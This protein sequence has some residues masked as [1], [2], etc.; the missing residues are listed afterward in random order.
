MQGKGAGAVNRVELE[1]Q[2][3][4]AALRQSWVREDKV[5]A[6]TSI[7][8][9]SHL[10]PDL[11]PPPEER[12]GSNKANYYDSISIKPQAGLNGIV[13]G[14]L[15]AVR[16]FLKDYN[17]RDYKDY[18]NTILNAGFVLRK[19]RLRLSHD[20]VVARRWLYESQLEEDYPEEEAAAA[21]LYAETEFELGT[22]AETAEETPAAAQMQYEVDLGTETELEAAEAA[23]QAAPDFQ[24]EAAEAA[25]PLDLW[26]ISAPAQESEAKEAHPEPA[27]SAASAQ[28]SSS[29]GSKSDDD[30]YDPLAAIEESWQEARRRSG[31]IAKPSFSP[32]ESLDLPQKAG[33]NSTPQ[34]V[35]NQSSIESSIDRMLAENR[36]SKQRAA[37]PSPRSL[38][39]C[40]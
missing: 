3:L 33:S 36:P 7:R 18:Y 15:R 4:C 39:K 17:P 11:L 21:E 19:P 40:R 12:N 26:G 23:A 22:A 8:E 14:Y 5:G 35:S 13:V 37:R 1:C 31:E 28:T 30:D 10:F 38:L 16:K 32:P 9:L 2:V 20:L 34:T 27:S 29:A 25:S 24:A 6:F